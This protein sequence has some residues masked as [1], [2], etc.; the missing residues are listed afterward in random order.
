VQDPLT[1]GAES[2]VRHGSFT[3]PTGPPPPYES[4]ISDSA[5]I[6]PASAAADSNTSSHAG[7]IPTV[8]PETTANGSSSASTSN[9][10]A[11][12]CNPEFEIVV[13]DPVKQGEGVSAYVSYKVITVQHVLYVIAAS[14][15]ARQWQRGARVAS[16]CSATC[17]LLRVRQGRSACWLVTGYSIVNC[18][19]EILKCRRTAL[20]A[21]RSI[22]ERF[23]IAAWQ[24]V[25]I[26][27]CPMTPWVAQHCVS[28]HEMP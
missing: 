19:Y 14:A 25:V 26:W 18:S 6:M 4:V 22:D 23:G 2:N 12:A 27:P 16:C 9:A 7:T 10:G 8:M 5:L 13:A 20:S 11:V 15:A 21:A 3:D 28:Q 17:G 24:G 1:F